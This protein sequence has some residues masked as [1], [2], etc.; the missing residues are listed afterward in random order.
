METMRVVM[1]NNTLLPAAAGVSKVMAARYG[2][3]Q[4]KKPRP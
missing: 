2:G 1:A 4:T 3:E